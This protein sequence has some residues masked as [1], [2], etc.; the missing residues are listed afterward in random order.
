MLGVAFFGSDVFCRQIFVAREHV[1]KTVH[2]FSWFLLR[3]DLGYMP[4]KQLLSSYAASVKRKAFLVNQ[5]DGIAVLPMWSRQDT[6]SKS[7]MLCA[8][9]GHENRRCN[10]Q[11]ESSIDTS[12]LK[13]PSLLLV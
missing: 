12:C 10:Q 5:S 13:T 2:L 6:R 11:V 8:S 1:C 4:H 9:D 3:L 7:K